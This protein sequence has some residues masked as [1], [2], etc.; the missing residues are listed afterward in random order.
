MEKLRKREGQRKSGRYATSWGW[1]QWIHTSRPHFLWKRLLNTEG[2]HYEW[3]NISQM[4]IAHE[5]DSSHLWLLSYS[6]VSHTWETLWGSTSGREKISLKRINWNANP[7]V[8][9]TCHVCSAHR[10]CVCLVWKTEVLYQKHIYTFLWFAKGVNVPRKSWLECKDIKLLMQ[11]KP[12]I[13]PY[14]VCSFPA[15]EGRKLC[16]SQRAG[17]SPGSTLHQAP[18]QRRS[19]KGVIIKGSLS[20]WNSAPYAGATK[21]F[22]IQ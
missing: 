16:S 2:K 20:V 18:S 1:Q 8:L 21:V 3:S 14:A 17:V 19:W 6:I 4:K 13:T 11:N 22:P 9:C 15:L 12:P 5:C 7:V 10:E